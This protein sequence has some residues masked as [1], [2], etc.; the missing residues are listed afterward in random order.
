MSLTRIPHA[1]LARASIA[2]VCLWLA[3]C[4]QPPGADLQKPAQSPAIHKVKHLVVIYAENHSFD[5]LYGLFPGADGVANAS[6]ASKLQLDHD[7]RPLREL[8]VFDR[9]G[10]PDPAYGRMPNGPFRIDGPPQNKRHDELVPS[11]IHAFWH[12]QEQINGGLNNRFAAVSQ[13]G[14]WGMGYYDGSA[15]KLWQWARE[16]TLA[17]RFFMGAFG[18]SYL[19]HHYLICACAPR[20]EAA[21]ATAGARL[22]AKG[23]LVKK[24]G[25]P[26]ANNAAVEYETPGARVTP[27]GWSVNT[28]QPPFQPSGI[29]PAVAGPATLADPAGSKFGGG[30]QAPVPPQTQATIGDRLNDM[31]VPWAWYSGGWNLALADGIQPPEAKRQ[32]IYG[33]GPNSPMFQAHHQPFNYYRRYAPGQADRAHL[34]DG[35]DFVKDIEA[36]TLPAVSFYKPAGRYTQHPSYTDVQT[37]DEHMADVL[38]RLRASPQWKDMLIV[39]TYDENGGYWDHVAPPTGPGWGDRFGP[40]TRVP[41]LLI[42]P[43]VRRGFVDHTP[44]DTTSILKF[45]TRRWNLAPLPGVREKPGDLSQA[46]QP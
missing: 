20:D 9:K 15:F 34:K 18:G 5:N 35:A 40:G 3:S 10:Q 28:S 41:A 22:D 14:G 8:V 26:S 30:G 42:G 31:N 19:N 29:P 24:A 12:N 33:G 17:D 45:I 4:A 32:I 36:G 43:N 6:A 38:T 44:Y 11:P 39:L 25:S 7:G 2:L 23:M 13:V 21:V 46:L 1:S 27:D 37:G 16:Y